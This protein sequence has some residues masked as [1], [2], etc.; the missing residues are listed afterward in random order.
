MSHKNEFQ[1]VIDSMHGYME[2]LRECEPICMETK[3]DRNSLRRRLPG[4]KGVYVLY[5]CC[6]PM[7]VGRSD[8]LADRLLSHGRPSSGSESATFAFNLAREKCSAPSTISR[9]ELKKDPNF[10]RL[11]AEAKEQV[12]KMEVR[13]VGMKSPIEQTIFEVYAHLELGTPFNS[14]ENH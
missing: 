8:Q 12:R 7:Y 13:V 9:Q 4:K 14:F 11:F 10:Q 3:S 1:D 2:Q 6:K 5:E